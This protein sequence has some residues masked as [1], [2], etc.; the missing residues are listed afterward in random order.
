ME[1]ARV[2]S[3]CPVFLSVSVKTECGFFLFDSFLIWFRNESFRK[4]LF[5][6]SQQASRSDIR[7]KKHQRRQR[8]K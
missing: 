8:I 6:R 7:K 2:R 5:V 4:I 1:I 3:L